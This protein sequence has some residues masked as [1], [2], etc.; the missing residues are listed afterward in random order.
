[1][2]EPHFKGSNGRVRLIKNILQLET[3]TTMVRKSKAAQSCIKNLGSNAQKQPKQPAVTMEE[4]EDEDTINI[5]GHAALNINLNKGTKRTSSNEGF[6][7]D[8]EDGSLSTYFNWFPDDIPLLQ[9]QS[10]SS[11]LNLFK[12]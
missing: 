3:Y 12:P 7:F 1:M 6:I 9:I 5:S 11:I 2:V 4:V 10:Y 8:E